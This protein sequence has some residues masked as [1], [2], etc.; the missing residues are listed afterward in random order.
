MFFLRYQMIY[1]ITVILKGITYAFMNIFRIKKFTIMLHDIL[2]SNT[3][4]VI[5]NCY[6]TVLIINSIMCFI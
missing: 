3:N 1:N 6:T 4:Y 2:I 5:N